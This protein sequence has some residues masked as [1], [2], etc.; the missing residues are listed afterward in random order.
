MYQFTGHD[1]RLGCCCKSLTDFLWIWN[2]FLLCVTFFNRRVIELC[3]VG[4]SSM[5]V[6]SPSSANAHR[7][8]Y[9]HT[10]AIKGH[11]TDHTSFITGGSFISTTIYTLT[12]CTQLYFERKQAKIIW[13]RLYKWAPCSLKPSKNYTCCH[14]ECSLSG[15]SRCNKG[16]LKD[17]SAR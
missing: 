6:V 12:V 13:K 1:S 11:T 2:W 9:L 5:W 14:K 15:C 3:I 16:K 8:F 10:K 7:L 4:A 17:I